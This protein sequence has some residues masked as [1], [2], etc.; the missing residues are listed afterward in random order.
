M[1]Y[2]QKRS[3]SRNHEWQKVTIRFVVVSDKKGHNIVNDSFAHKPDI[4]LVF[5]GM[6]KLRNN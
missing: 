6:S 2:E 1:N 5:T 3:Q 4:L